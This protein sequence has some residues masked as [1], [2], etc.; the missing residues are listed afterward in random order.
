MCG[1]VSA[2]VILKGCSLVILQIYGTQLLRN[3]TDDYAGGKKCI[4]IGITP[5]TQACETWRKTPQLL[6]P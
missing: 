2:L 4:F 6:T 3:I 1:L 5:R